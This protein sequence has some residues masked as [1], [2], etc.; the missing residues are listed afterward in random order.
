MGANRGRRERGKGGS[1]AQGIKQ[2]LE[3][4]PL[5]SGRRNDGSLDLGT[6]LRQGLVDGQRHRVGGLEE[7]RL[8]Q[9]VGD[10]RGREGAVGQCAIHSLHVKPTEGVSLHPG[11]WKDQ[12]G[13]S[14]PLWAAEG[15][16][17]RAGGRRKSVRGGAGPTTAPHTARWQPQHPHTPGC[18][19][20]RTW[21]PCHFRGSF[22]TAAASA[23][24]VL[25]RHCRSLWDDL[26]TRRVRE[27]PPERKR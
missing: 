14:R 16:Q 18:P 4:R 5:Q 10:G 24:R 11:I 6:G 20:P 12:K 22:S 1:K 25:S 13:A 19:T 21:M 7:Q 26:A 2:Q 9:G 17:G 15:P 3:S 8:R 27:E 23:A